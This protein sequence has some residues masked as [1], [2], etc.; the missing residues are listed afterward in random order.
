MSASSVHFLRAAT[1]APTADGEPVTTSHR[2][3]TTT[4]PES[5][6]REEAFS[7]SDMPRRGVKADSTYRSGRQ[8]NERDDEVPHSQYP[9]TPPC[10]RNLYRISVGDFATDLSRTE[11]LCKALC[12]NLRLSGYDFVSRPYF[13]LFN[14]TIIYETS[15][16]RS[17]HCHRARMSGRCL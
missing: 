4:V 16:T 5:E 6:S 9:V 14:K 11:I 12:Q 1:G 17:V 13:G 15:P 7:A 10:Y 3:G 2:F 8:G